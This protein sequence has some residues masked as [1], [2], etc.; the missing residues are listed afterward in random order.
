MRRL[1][2][3]LL[4]LGLAA[5]ASAPE[6][7]SPSPP[8]AAHGPA[9]AIPSA[10]AKKSPYAPAQEDLSK[11][12]DYK[13]GGLYAAHIPDTTPDY[14]PDVDAIPEP[15]VTNEPRSRVGNRSSYAVLGKEYRVLDDP[16]G[17]VEEGLASYYG[18]KFHG[19]RTSNLEVYDMYAFTAAHKTLPLPSFARVTNRDNGKSIVVRVND[20]GPFHAGRVI[21]LSY[22]AAVKLGITQRGTGRVEVRALTPG[23][24]SSPAVANAVLVPAPASTLDRLVAAMPIASAA[25]SGMPP[26]VRIAT[27]KPTPTP[28]ATIAPT[29]TPSVTATQSIA[30]VANGASGASA[31]N[32]YRFDMRQD[33]KAMSA[34]E[35]E[36]W[37]T[38]RQV[39]VAT[40]KPGRPNSAIT[41]LV[42][43]QQPISA[44]PQPMSVPVPAATITSAA[45]ASGVTLQVASFSARGNADR[46]L[47]MLHG[48]GID[49]ARLNDADANGQKVWRLRVGPLDAAAA[50]ELAARIAGLGFGQPQRVRD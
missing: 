33:G 20:R 22:A 26:G 16:S 6:K 50:P 9:P 7:P 46:A 37:M 3:A 2:A 28:A 39:R 18:N 38:S 35:F 8:V 10:G 1:L 24:A 25:A 17:Y 47:A 21:D 23:T 43:L 49:G 5:C 40:G 41:A 27:G 44:Q 45:R 32:D 14:I 42:P 31:G 12:G 15:E 29:P 13:A 34:D 11:R 30:G 36:A 19:R 4:S 48:A